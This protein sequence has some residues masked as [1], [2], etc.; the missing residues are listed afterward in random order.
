MHPGNFGIA[1]DDD[2]IGV[3]AGMAPAPVDRVAHHLK[4][5]NLIDHVIH[6]RGA[7]RG[8]MAAFMPARVA[9]RAIDDTVSQ[10]ERHRPPTAP[11]QDAATGQNDM[12][13]DPQQ[14]IADGGAVGPLH[15]RLH[16]VACNIGMVPFGSHQ[17]RL[18]GMAGL[19]AGQRIIP[20]G[21]DCRAAVGSVEAHGVPICRL[22]PA[23]AIP[24]GGD[25]ARS[26]QNASAPC[27]VTGGYTG[28]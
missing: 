22:P 19:C 26:H 14:G 7:K 23:L 16:L 8:A 21:D 11:Q 27:A 9:G 5:R 6:P 28:G 3:V 25:N 20:G 18:G 24:S 17:P 2:R 12:Q 10:P 15:Q 1:A 4:R 13:R